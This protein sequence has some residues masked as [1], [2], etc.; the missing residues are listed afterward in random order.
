MSTT[1]RFWITGLVPATFTP[2]HADGNLNLALIAP[3]VEQL[4][5]DG[6]TGLYVCGSTGEGVSMTSAERMAVTDAFVAAVAGRLPVIVQ[7]GHNSIAE[8]CLLAEHAQKAGADAVSATPPSYFKPPTLDALIDCMAEIA[9]AA[10]SLPFYYYHIPSMTGVTPNVA[11]LLREGA[12]RIPTLVGVKFS[13]TA[14]FDMQAALAVDNGRYNLLFGSDEMLL[15]GLCGG[16]HGAVGSTYNFAAPLYNRILAAFAAGD[17]A[18]AQHL[19]GQAVAMVNLLVRHGG[20]AA[21]KSV[22]AFLGLD[23]GPVRLPQVALTAEHRDRLREDLMDIDFF[24]W[25]R[26][27]T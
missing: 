1:D 15:S 13:H 20:N 21:I 22:M 2:F 8:A 5:A 12:G 14:V 24:V 6:V 10:D 3:M 17:L 26:N 9:A 27:A 23:C 11:A 25:G 19:Q 4:I 16:A 7:V 18:T